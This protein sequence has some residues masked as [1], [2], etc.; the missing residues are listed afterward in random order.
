MPASGSVSQPISGTPLT[1]TDTSTGITVSSRVLTIYSATGALLN[2]INM[3][4]SL[5]TTYAITGDQWLRFVLTLNSGAYT[6]TVDFLSEN[7][8]YNGLINQVK[9]GCGCSGDSLC[10]DPAKA[11]LSDKA[12][13]FYTTYGFA[14]N[15]DT[16]IK[17]ADALIL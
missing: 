12:A 2:T 17:A 10:A 6:A 14:V 1:F 15:A 4:A 8:Y 3:G 11:M 13:L 7:F 16:C 5:T 9:S